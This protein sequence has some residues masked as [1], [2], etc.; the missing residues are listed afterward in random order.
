LANNIKLLFLICCAFFFLGRKTE[1]QSVLEEPSVSTF[2]P[3]LGDSFFTEK[4]PSFTGDAGSDGPHSFERPLR[5][6]N[7]ELP[8]RLASFTREG[9]GSD[10]VKIDET[11]LKHP[12]TERY[13]KMYTKPAQLRWLASVLKQGEPYMAFIRDEIEKRGM[14]QYILYL[15]VIES[16][17]LTT[18][19]SISGAGGMWQFMKNSIKPYMQINEWVDERRDFY[20]STLAALSKLQENYKTFGDWLLAVAAYNCGA[21]EMS[22]VIKQT[23]IKDYWEL[24]NRNKLK[25]ETSAYIPKLMAVYYITS[26]PRRAGLEPGYSNEVYEW[27]LIPLKKQVDLRVLADLAGLDKDELRSANTELL[28]NVSPPPSSL[29]D[30]YKLKVRKKDAQAAASVLEREDLPLVKHYIHIIKHGDTLSALALYYGVSVPAIENQ[31]PSVNA[32]R[33]IPGSR[34]LIPALKDVP[35]A[36]SFAPEELR[37]APRPGGE[38]QGSVCTVRSGD[39]LYG[40]ARRYGVSV[41]SLA[42]ANG[43][44]MDAVLSVGRNLIIP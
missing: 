32:R 27:T 17:F 3:V 18:A 41:K 23:G 4:A 30:D 14:P 24:N 37:E 19:V 28:L 9:R 10:G 15:P 6:K 44:E 34:L 16:G 36:P 21:G 2:T 40:I 31:N 33:L 43:I 7:E 12:L 22:R 11:S 42:E 35:P 29:A 20:K 26:C 39:T 13:I 5:S 25:K 1:A 8:F 38:N